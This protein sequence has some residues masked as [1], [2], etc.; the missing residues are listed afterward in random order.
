MGRLNARAVAPTGRQ[1]MLGVATI[2]EVLNGAKSVDSPDSDLWR[3]PEDQLEFCLRYDL[4]IFVT[5]CKSDTLCPLCGKMA[6]DAGR[7]HRN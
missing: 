2:S 7:T 6:Q 5:L 3:M 1:K 4:T